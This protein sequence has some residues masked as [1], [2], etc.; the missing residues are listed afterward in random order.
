MVNFS[1]KILFGAEGRG[2]ETRTCVVFDHFC[3]IVVREGY[4]LHESDD[5]S[6]ARAEDTMAIV[7]VRIIYNGYP[8][9]RYTVPNIRISMTLIFLLHGSCSDTTGIGNESTMISRAKSDQ[10]SP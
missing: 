1:Y 9:S 2:V 4:D 3:R 10:A 6:D 5:P 8:D 7:S